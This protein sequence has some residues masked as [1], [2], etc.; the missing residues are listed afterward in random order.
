MDVLSKLKPATA[1]RGGARRDSAPEA[2]S[3]PT[4]EDIL[5]TLDSFTVENKEN[6]NNA[7]PILRRSLDSDSKLDT[8]SNSQ[9]ED[10]GGNLSTPAS[11]SHSYSLEWEKL[12]SRPDMMRY[13]KTRA[14]D[15]ELRSSRFRSVVWKLFLEVLPANKDEW[16]TKTRAG[17][18]R[19]EDLKN[20]LIVNPRKAVDSVDITLNN[21]L[22]QDEESPWNKFFQDNELRLTIKQDVI[23]T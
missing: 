19:F 22:S 5:N 7:E 23:R 12:F 1:T 3:Q 4:K 17:R 21:P 11:L 15:G 6:N 16:I 10:L 20:K 9:W 18:A 8:I 13:L 14:M 2:S